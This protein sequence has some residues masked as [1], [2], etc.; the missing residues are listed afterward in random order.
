VR[1]LWRKLFGSGARRRYEA[2]LDRATD[3]LARGLHAEALATLERGLSDGVKGHGEGAEELLVAHYAAASAALAGGDLERAEAH[4]R[5]GVSLAARHGARSEPPEHRFLETLAAIEERRDTARESD[6]L[7][8]ALRAYADA[9]LRAGD[10]RS[11]AAA[12]NRLGLL[13][14]RT[15]RR[16]EAAEELAE[17]LAIRRSLGAAEARATLESAYN[18]ATC[19]PLDG[20]AGD[21]AL[22]DAASLLDEVVRGTRD[23]TDGAG[24]ELAESAHHTLGVVRDERGELDEA[25]R[26]YERS[27]SLRAKRLGDDH[28]SLRPTLSRLAR[29]EHRAGRLVFALG[30]YERALAIARHELSEDDA[31]VRALERWRDALTSGEGEA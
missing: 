30:Y 25:R 8:R 9:S 11:V 4:C 2:A 15:E 1:D 14:A 21:E 31:I 28:A 26:L 20:G 24:R 7:E 5:L 18:L 16:D 19:R 23:A 17:A 3:E 29:L 10:R 12:K 22:A 6:A 13:L 27:L